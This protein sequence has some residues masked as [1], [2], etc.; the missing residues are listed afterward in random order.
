MNKAYKIIL[1]VLGG[2]DVAF[3]IFIP[4]A[5]AILIISVIK[6][7]IIVLNFLLIVG[8]L[9]SLYRAIEVAGFDTIE[10]IIKK[11]ISRDDRRNKRTR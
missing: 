4:F 3:N 10:Y 11:I 5:L 9:S 8:S 6:V 1:A 7:D 2:C